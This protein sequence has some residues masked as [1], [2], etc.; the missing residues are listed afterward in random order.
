MSVRD[1]A[2]QHG[3]IAVRTADRTW[4]RV[5]PESVELFEGD[6]DRPHVVLR[7]THLQEASIIRS[8]PYGRLEDRLR[9]RAAR[10]GGNAA[11][12]VRRQDASDLR[13]WERF[14]E[15]NRGRHITALIVRITDPDV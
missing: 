1:W 3:F 13:W 15:T 5:A 6:I 8:D 10:R 9:K 12:I 7:S 2:V 14:D 4:T 11:I